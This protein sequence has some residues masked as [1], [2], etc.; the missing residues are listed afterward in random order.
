[1]SEIKYKKRNGEIVEATIIGSYD[2]KGKKYT[3]IKAGKKQLLIS[4]KQ[5]IK[6]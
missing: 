3:K 4:E 6:E 5:I 1:M 2:Y